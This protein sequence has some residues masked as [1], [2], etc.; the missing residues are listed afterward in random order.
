MMS[1]M[2]IYEDG[3]LS[4]EISV[5]D[6][7]IWLSADQIASIFDVNRPAIVKHIGNIYKTEELDKNSTC[8]ILE[9]V[10]KDGKKRKMNFYNL[11]MIIAAG[12]RVNSKKATA[13][14][15]WST[16]ILKDH[17][18]K[19][20][21]INK[22]R[23][24]KNYDEFLRVVEDIKVLSQNSGSVKAEDVL[25]LI[26]SFSATWFGLDSYDREELPKEG[27]SKVNLEFEVEKLYKDVAI[28]KQELM[29]KGEASEIFATEKTKKSLEGIFGNVFQS[30][31]G[32]D[33]YPTVEE[34]AAH[35]LYFIVKNHPFNDGNK[36]TGAFSFVWL[37]KRAGF[38]VE[39]Y[40]NPNAL[41][42]LTLLIAESNPNDKD[43]MVGL[44]LLMLRDQ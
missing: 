13:F 15:K 11:D 22:E 27:I 26:K 7:T 23:L 21:T 16:N 35:L 31:F 41:T 43:R 12:Y 30:V 4:I 25:E 37:L 9:Q 5:E 10:A 36:R 14:R 42:A 40:I 6:E 44:V 32:E 18:I 8:S 1:D 34:K 3:H 24:Q 28:F 38:D 29:K 20:Y 39:T 2:V 19:G 33:A 17:L